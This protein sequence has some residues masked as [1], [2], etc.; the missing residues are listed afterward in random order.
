MILTMNKAY[1][2]GRVSDRKALLKT[3]GRAGVVHVVPVS[4]GNL[5]AN[6]AL[7]AQYDAARRAFAQV[8][9][10]KGAEVAENPNLSAS[11]AI[12]ELNE[13][14][15]RNA[16]ANNKL[17]NIHRQ[18][19]QLEVWGDTRVSD[20]DALDAAGVRL[21]FFVLPGGAVSEEGVFALNR[22]SRGLVVAAVGDA[23][24]PE[25]AE[26]L[27]RPLRDRP[28]LRKEAAD[29]DAQLHKDAER[30]VVLSAE[31]TKIA[32]ELARLED[33]VTLDRVQKAALESDGLFALQGWV[34]ESK[35]PALQEALKAAN[36]EAALQFTQPAEDEDPPTAVEYAWWARPIKGLF[37]ILGTVP[38]Y[39]E[40]D[41]APYFM[42]ALPIFAAML[43]G[44]AGYGLLCALLP[45]IFRKACVKMAGRD[46]TNLII[47]F[48]VLTM[49]WGVLTANYFGIQPENLAFL[50]TKGSLYVLGGESG[51]V[52][53]LIAK[54]GTLGSIAGI[55]CKLAPLYPLN[56]QG[57]PDPVM[58]RNLL[59]MISFIIGSIHLVVA[60]L[61]QAWTNR[62]NR[63][64]IASFGFALL[65]A[66]MLGVV[67]MLLFKEVDN[68]KYMWM[69]M[70]VSSGLMIAGG[71]LIV[72][73]AR[74]PILGL[75]GNI[76]PAISTFSDTMSYIRLMAV[77]MAS[78]YIAFAFNYLT[79]L[80]STNA[81][82]SLGL[83]ILL[84]GHL[85]N[86]ALCAIA[87]FAHGVRLNMLE[88][89][90][91]AGVQWAGHAYAPFAHK[92]EPEG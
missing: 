65:L 78:Y 82:W 47:I 17:T 56:G 13:I 57:S 26:P 31:K 85:L 42:I 68:G 2:V 4:S 71:A 74:N 91:N 90:N 21:R 33:A 76:L 9:A 34:P 88:F 58:S 81:H 75:I 54:G 3:L 64:G 1:I 22:T 35:V 87:I 86:A 51:N 52:Q 32:K 60:Q 79:G 46:M 66:G 63:T 6:E 11:D 7:V 38:G 8:D 36:L 61:L 59:M 40:P 45:L 16:E 14:Q 20:L 30:I 44:D 10:V 73:S 67:W 80:I 19:D 15:K 48:G 72:L 41:L 83:V 27:E 69:P 25:D 49:G 62:K 24:L 23:Q 43:I 18:I 28:S 12:A 5:S 92:A 50:D 29:L 53:A 37:D 77:G 89:S 55:M 39:R 84:C 70:S